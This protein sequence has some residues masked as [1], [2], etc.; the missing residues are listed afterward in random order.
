MQTTWRHRP[1]RQV[2]KPHYVILNVQF[3][4]IRI[5]SVLMK[6]RLC[7][8]ANTTSKLRERAEKASDYQPIRAKVF[9][10]SKK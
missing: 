3:R 1:H 9:E 8:N 5:A 6:K 7:S 4:E 10:L 2:H